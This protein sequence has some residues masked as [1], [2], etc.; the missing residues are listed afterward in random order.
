MKE[1]SKEEPACIRALNVNDGKVVLAFVELRRM[2]DVSATSP[3][4]LFPE[5]GAELL[6]S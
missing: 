2:M 5:D 6:L 3:L 4:L 1:H